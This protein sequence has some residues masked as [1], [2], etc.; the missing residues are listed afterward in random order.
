MLQSEPKDRVA[1]LMNQMTLT[2][3]IIKL[4]LTS[5]IILLLKTGII[6]SGMAVRGNMTES[7]WTGIG[8]RGRRID[9]SGPV[10]G[11]IEIRAAEGVE[12][13]TRIMK[14]MKITMKYLLH[15]IAIVRRVAEWV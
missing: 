13:K 6:R 7:M 3:M 11:H 5:K 12:P 4:I 9:M 8:E 2:I 1:N 14:I 10:I 15:K